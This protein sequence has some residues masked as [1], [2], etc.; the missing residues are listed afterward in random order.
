MFR[1]SLARP[2]AAFI[3]GPAVAGLVMAACS[4]DSHAACMYTDTSGAQP[5]IMMC[6]EASANLREQMRQAC[7]QLASQI[8]AD[9]GVT[10]NVKLLDG[11]CPPQGTLGA[12]E[13]SL[14]GAT[15]TVW[16]Y[17]QGSPYRT[18]DELKQFCESAG[19]KY[20]AP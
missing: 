15:M 8:P 18:A 4:D 5:A 1:H 2:L 11:T 19:H 3:L 14:G 6:E 7:S 20:V 16:Y 13:V 9:A 12:C 10:M 17:A